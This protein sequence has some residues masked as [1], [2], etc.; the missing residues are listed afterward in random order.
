VRKFHGLVFLGAGPHSVALAKLL[1]ARLDEA[2]SIAGGLQQS[3]QGGH[4]DPSERLRGEFELLDAARDIVAALTGRDFTYGDVLPPWWSGLGFCAHGKIEKEACRPCGR[5]ATASPDPPK[6]P[7]THATEY[8][9][10]DCEICRPNP[11]H[12]DPAE[13]SAAADRAWEGRNSCPMCGSARV[14]GASKCE[15]GHDLLNP[16]NQAQEVLL[17]AFQGVDPQDLPLHERAYRIARSLE[18]SIGERLP[19]EGD[20]PAEAPGERK[21][22]PSDRKR[23]GF[24]SVCKRQFSKKRGHPDCGT[25]YSEE[26]LI[27]A[28]RGEMDYANRMGV[29]ATSEALRAAQERGSGERAAV[30]LGGQVRPEHCGKPEAGCLWFVNSRCAC[31]CCT[32]MTNRTP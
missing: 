20:P 24:C 1:H 31:T 6:R 13:E 12:V 9:S 3:S 26:I 7:H 15:E 11:A 27:F 29:P 18:S 23:P 8:E 10:A 2:L 14:V 21:A 25:E 4:E 19:P 32:G 28:N 17:N 5:S 30:R 22:S 16:T